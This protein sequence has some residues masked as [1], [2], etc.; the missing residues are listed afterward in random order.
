[1][2]RRAGFLSV[3]VLGAAVPGAIV[4]PPL[5]AQQPA[6]PWGGYVQA[7]FTQ[8]NDETGFSIR[9]AKLWLNGAAPVGRGLYYKLQGLF[10]ATN[11]GALT[12]QDHFGYLLGPQARIK[13][14]E[15]GGNLLV[16][17]L[18]LLALGHDFR[19]L[20]FYLFG[21][22]FEQFGVTARQGQ[23]NRQENSSDADK[24]KGSAL[25]RRDFL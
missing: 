17:R 7:R 10:R 4:T 13:C 25:H 2:K 3:V 24:V 19:L 21:L 23:R 14:L 6:I 18:D 1:M 12:L 20:L 15:V 11:G 22:L 5:R 9:R 16:E 8:S